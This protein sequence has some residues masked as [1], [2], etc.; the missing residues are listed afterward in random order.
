MEMSIRKAAVMGQFYPQKKSEVEKTFIEYNKIINENIAD[1]SNLDIKSNALI[2]PHAGYMYS[3]LT[4]NIAFRLLKNYNPKTIVVIGPS[5]HVYLDGTSV[6]LYDSYETPLGLVPIDTILAKTLMSKFDLQFFK[7]AHSEH[8][9]EVQM[10]FIK[11]Y[12]SD[13]KVVEL[14]Y[15][16]EDS[17]NLAKI[18]EFILQ[19]PDNAVVISTD[20]SHYHN[21][22]K[23]NALDSLCL[24]AIEELS[25]EKLHNNCEACGKIGVEAILRY[26]KK[27][28]L[29]P[30]LLDYRTSADANGDK[31]QVVGYA[32]VVFSD[33]LR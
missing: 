3:G 24:K 32:S 22:N 11:Y 16:K 20:L 28:G 4:A 19:N 6:S 33:N 30:K 21:I 27:V 14:V 5:H 9:T 13:T 26:A 29:T 23:A 17:K 8:S 1:K 18:V 7:D 25:P 2:V 12:L 31:T 10:P 15:G